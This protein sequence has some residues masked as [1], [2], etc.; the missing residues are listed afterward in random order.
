MNVF[1][2]DKWNF[3]TCIDPLD[4][5]NSDLNSWQ[6]V[7]PRLRKKWIQFSQSK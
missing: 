3:H 1:S 2:S 4:V 6:L 7:S 5:S